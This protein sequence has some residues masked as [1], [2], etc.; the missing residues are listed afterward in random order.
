MPIA[1]F[2]QHVRNTF[3]LHLRTLSLIFEKVIAEWYITLS[4]AINFNATFAKRDKS[5]ALFTLRT[6]ILAQIA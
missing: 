2:Y 5:S 6:F 3:L 4:L 1:R